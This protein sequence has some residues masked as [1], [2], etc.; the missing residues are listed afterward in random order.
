MSGPVGSSTWFGKPGYNLDQSLRFN[1]DD[2][3]FL[4][5]TPAS[6]GNLRTWTW[7]AW[8]KR[9]SLGASTATR[10]ILFEAR[11]DSDTFM[12][13]GFIDNEFHI[14]DIDGSTDYGIQ[15][16]SV[17]RDVSAWY[18]I[19]L[20]W[21][22]TLADGGDDRVRLYVNGTFHQ[23][24]DEYGQF[25]QNY[26]GSVNAAVPHS[27]AKYTDQS[28]TSDLY[29]AEVNF[30][31]GLELGPENFGTTNEHGA[32]SPIEYAGAYGTNGFYL[33]FKQDYTVEGFSTVLYKGNSGTQ[34]VGGVGFQPDW[35][36][37]KRRSGA[38]EHW[39]IDS[40]RGGANVLEPQGSGAENDLGDAGVGFE[41]DGF[42][43]DYTGGWN[44]GNQTGYTY[45]AW[46]W[47]MG[48]SNATLTAGSIDS[49]VRANPTYGQSIVSY[50]GTGS[51]A[52]VAHGLSSAPEWIIVKDRSNSNSW[53]VYHTSL[54]NT[55]AAFLDLNAAADT[56]EASYWNSTS[57]TSSLINLGTNT[58]VNHNS[59]T[60][61]AYAFHSV[62]GYSKFGTY[63]GDA[64]TDNSLSVTVGFKTA[65]LMVKRTDSTGNWII[66]DSAR[67]PDVNDIDLYLKANTTDTEATQSGNLFKFTSTAFT[68]GGNLADVNADGGTYVYMAFADKR[69]FAYYL[70]QSGN[71]NDF[72]SNNLTESDIMV[73][74]PTNN[75]STFNFLDKVDSV[76]AEGNLQATGAGNS[77][78]TVRSTFAMTSGSWY[79]E[80]FCKAGAANGNNHV[81]ISTQAEAL[82]GI[83]GSN[84]LGSSDTSYGYS[85]NDNVY[86]NGSVANNTGTTWTAGDIIGITFTGSVIKWYKNNNLIATVSSIPDLPRDEYCFTSTSYST[87]MSMI[88]NFGQDSSFASN[89]PPQFKRDLRNQAEFYY[90]PPA[91][92]LA[93]CSNNLPEPAFIPSEYFNTVLW[94]GDG[95][96]EVVT[97]VGFQSDWIWVKARNAAVNHKVFDAV[98][99]LGSLRPNT[100]GAEDTNTSENL[101]SYNSDGFTIKDPDH[102]VDTRTV[103]AWNWK[104]GN[105]TLASNAFT[106]G[107][108]AST[109]SRDVDAGFSIVKY[110]GTGSN[111]TVG[112]GLSSAPEMILA[113]S[114]HAD[115]AWAVYHASLASNSHT[116]TLNST[117]ISYDE[118]NKFTGTAPT[119]SVFSVGNHG[120]NVNTKQQIAYCFHSVDGYSAVSSYIGN[121]NANGTFVY[122]GFKPAFIL[123]KCL[124][125]THEWVM[126]DN[127]R[128]TGTVKYEIYAN[129]ANAEGS[130]DSGVR[131][132]STGFKLTSDNSYVN[133]NAKTFIYLAFANT[134][135]KYSNAR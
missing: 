121:G 45:V 91:G 47:D 75:F 43:L 20:V 131:F 87:S 5:R 62:S 28:L 73:D 41:N 48:G 116:L 16:N 42:T 119:S 102:I 6:A 60:Y 70:D 124:D 31:D 79:A 66:V 74:S 71:N 103:V 84:F 54:G 104:A 108:I 100:T 2:L 123:I 67:N 111:S 106:Q 128:Q 113:K 35:I 4:T 39:S 30:I 135:F 81:G 130:D 12:Q 17:F 44:S 101:T 3:A 86:N 133:A 46:N 18:H 1:D 78:D 97:G 13:M 50:T 65:F 32:W 9:A 82:S 69:E 126:L 15:T 37:G 105:A 63:T 36:W 57:P 80:F 19:L 118:S 134:P 117:A 59:H 83:S 93:L 122:T 52:T 55:A 132:T 49:T 10:D 26:D 85:D 76:L 40:V 98:R 34:Y 114:D 21:N 11:E 109:C 90:E 112:H 92:F 95:S 25:P 53:Q 23:L 38:K 77:F 24:V 88:A 7:S 29:L 72:K 14:Y 94:T 125:A 61:I 127:T 96:E 110:T 22:T 64:T 129:K 8:V 51:N 68:L 58:K 27:L 99:G 33:P 56:S 115:Y 89:K 107:S 120:T